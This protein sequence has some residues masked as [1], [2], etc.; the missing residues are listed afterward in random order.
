MRGGPSR[1]LVCIA[2]INA[3]ASP[4]P[5]FLDVDSEYPVR[6][7]QSDP[8]SEKPVRL[9]ACVFGRVQGVNFRYYTQREANALGLT[10][11]VANRFDGSL[12]VVAEGKKAALQ[13]LLSFLHHGPPSAR[14][15]RVA[16]E[17]GEATGEYRRFR[18]RYLR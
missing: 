12:E 1:M 7:S 14:V 8:S 17:W 5:G 9:Q 18:V 2:S 11:W 13:R 6:T 15:D 3:G 16:S 10:G 4:W